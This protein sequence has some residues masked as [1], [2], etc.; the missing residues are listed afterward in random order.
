VIEIHSLFMA[1]L[2]AT[3]GCAGEVAGRT[4]VYVVSVNG[5]HRDMVSGRVSSSSSSS[6]MRYLRKQAK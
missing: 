2:A 6:S 3:F 4:P 1:C 5:L